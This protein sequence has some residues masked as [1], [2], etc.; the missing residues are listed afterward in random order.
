MSFIK[1][2][3]MRHKLLTAFVAVGVAILAIYG[4]NSRDE[5]DLAGESPAGPETASSN[6]HVERSEPERRVERIISGRESIMRTRAALVGEARS[7]N[8]F[9]SYQIYQDLSRCRSLA[10]KRD[11]L[12]EYASRNA[13]SAAVEAIVGQIAEDERLC[14]GIGSESIG[15]RKDWIIRAARQGNVEAQLLFFGVVTEE[16]DTP[17]KIVANVDE[18]SRYK[19]EALRHLRSAARSGSETALFNLAMAYHDGTLAE[20]DL[21]LAYGYMLV[22]EK[23]GRVKSASHYLELWGREL[24]PEDLARARSI[25]LQY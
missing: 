22:V 1:K 8:A 15:E 13:D 10:T 21:S 16:F 17:E 19:T 3:F 4:L 9:A 11:V 6:A 20:K 18:I 24:G 7:G 14:K 25:S 23:K 12:E 2:V 5:D